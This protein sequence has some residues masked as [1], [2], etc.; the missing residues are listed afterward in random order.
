MT[1]I[2]PNQCKLILIVF[3]RMRSMLMRKMPEWDTIPGTG[4][5]MAMDP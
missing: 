2:V 1:Y 3:A 4:Y 5:Q